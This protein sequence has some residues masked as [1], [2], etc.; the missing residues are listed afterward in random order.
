LQDR[1]GS[2]QGA[3]AKLNPFQQALLN[4]V[5]NGIPDPGLPPGTPP[6]TLGV[7]Y[8]SPNV[9]AQFNLF[10]NNVIPSQCFDPLAVNL[11]KYVPGPAE[12][13]TRTSRSRTTETEGIRPR[14]A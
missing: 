7:P 12:A 4:D 13:Q 10:P 9:A 1:C 11:L 5:I 3:A 8:N 2:G 6:G 14:S